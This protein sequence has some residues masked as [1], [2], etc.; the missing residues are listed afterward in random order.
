MSEDDFRVIEILDEYSILINY[1]RSDG[2]DEDDKVRIKSIGPEVTDPVTKKKLG[3]LD[4]I[5][6]ILT[7]VYVYDE[8]SL[9]RN[10]VTLTKNVLVSPL[11]QFQ[12]SSKENKPI[13][14]DKKDISGK[15][16]PD[17]KTIK[18]GDIVEIL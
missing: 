14:I 5:K 15:R 2:A 4:S 12:T 18:I 11:S 13:D 7:I 3:T 8:F 1:G 17:N 6:A 16:L 10:V 9:C